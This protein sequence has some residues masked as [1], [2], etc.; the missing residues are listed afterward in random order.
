[1]AFN[2]HVGDTILHAT[3][4]AQARHLAYEIANL[5]RENTTDICHVTESKKP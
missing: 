5:I 4:E 1:M 3:T 2:V